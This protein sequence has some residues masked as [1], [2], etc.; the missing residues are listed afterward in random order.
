MKTA[1]G[2][3]FVLPM[4]NEREN[5]AA[6][7]KKI[8]TLAGELTDD[9]EIVIVDD[10]ST[11]GSVDIVEKLAKEDNS[12]KLFR[13]KKNSKFGGAFALGFKKAEKNIILYTDSDMPV[14]D[15]DM[16]KSFPLIEEYDI[17]TGYSKIKKGDTLTRKIISKAYNCIIQTI[18]RLDIKDI[19]SGYKII[20]G[21]VVKDLNF[22]SR[23]PFVDVEIFV[24]AAKMKCKIFQ[25]PLVFRSR[26]GGKSYISGIKFI[27]ATFIDIVRVKLKSNGVTHKEAHV[28]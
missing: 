27:G 16:K 17:V 18:F 26:E 20:R 3:S 14:S 9:H 15:E 12:I 11:D 5:I 25:Y 1:I 8:Q 21:D 4:F 7:I 24:H 2:I 6:T 19:N 28:K 22:I 13:M 23:S 10:A